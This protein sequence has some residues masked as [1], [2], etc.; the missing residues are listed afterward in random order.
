MD[1]IVVDRADGIV[2][3]R[4]NRPEKKNAISAQMWDELSVALADVAANRDDR[5]MVVTG[6][7]DAFCAGQDL[8]DP[9]NNA[10]FDGVGGALHTMRFI[11][12]IAQALHDLTI[13]TIAAVNGV[14]VGAG[15]NLAFGCDIVVAAQSARFSQIFSARGLTI[16]FGGSR[17][18]PRMIGLHKA[19][20]LAFTADIVDAPTAERFGLVN[21]VVPD[22]DLASEVQA[23]AAKIA[24]QAPLALSTIKRHLNA[25]ASMTL[26]EALEAEAQAQAM[27]FSSEDKDEAF[28]AFLEKRTP[29]YRGA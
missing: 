16:D 22:D 10:R 17:L 1:T 28:A 24:S 26:A 3:L 5:V 8:G 12:S 25:S 18:L 27:L 20:E 14:A 11:G 7:A 15:A 21:R 4:L 2:T 23:L 19:K 13:P 29:N 9:E 6:T